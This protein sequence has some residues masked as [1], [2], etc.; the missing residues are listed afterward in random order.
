MRVSEGIFDFF[1]TKEKT[2]ADDPEYKGWLRLYT[3]NPDV[4][5]MHKRHKEF[6]QFYQS[7]TTNEGFGDWFKSTV[8]G[9]GA[10]SY[11]DYINFGKKYLN[12]KRDAELRAL[13]QK[14][15]P[16]L[17]KHEIDLNRVMRILQ[18]MRKERSV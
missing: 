12:F 4:A 13:L 15:F 11:D 1:K 9:S 5:E 16:E 3:K 17:D 10:K 6:L 8:L 18:Q 7:Q 2:L 14:K